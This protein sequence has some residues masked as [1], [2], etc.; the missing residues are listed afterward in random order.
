[1]LIHVT[2]EQAKLLLSLG[3]DYV[4]NSQ[5]PMKVMYFDTRSG[6]V[7]NT[8]RL[9]DLALGNLTITDEN[10]RILNLLL[11]I[12]KNIDDQTL[13]KLL[14]LTPHKGCTHE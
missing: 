2:H 3:T 1:M 7:V 11:P 6:R 5:L 4:L 13:T 10:L 8:H 12:N 9:L 14:E